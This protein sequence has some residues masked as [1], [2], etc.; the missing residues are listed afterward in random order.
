MHNGPNLW[1]AILAHMPPGSVIAGGAIRDW[2]LDVEPKDIDVFVGPHGS[3]AWDA[4]SGLYRI[5]G[6]HEREEEYQ[7]LNNINLVSTG[8][9]FDRRVDLVELSVPVTGESLV[10]GFD[11]AVNQ[12]WFDGDMIYRTTPC[13]QDLANHTV[14]L[15]TDDRLERSLKRFARFNER[16]GG[17]WRLVR[18]EEIAHG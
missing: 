12:T 16:M 9:L 7:A 5:D 15:I 8:T 1:K 11:F 14:T 2:F 6:T 10:A 18:V 3:N 4:R 17:G 13:V